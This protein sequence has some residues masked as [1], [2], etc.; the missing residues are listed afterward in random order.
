[1]IDKIH[2]CGTRVLAK[3]EATEAEKNGLFIPEQYRDKNQFARVYAIGKDTKEVKKGDKILTKK[4]WGE[5]VPV[6]ED[7]FI[8]KEEEILAYI[9]EE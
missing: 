7:F 6:G 4:H 5:G 3:R 1:M 8:I 2:P 9:R